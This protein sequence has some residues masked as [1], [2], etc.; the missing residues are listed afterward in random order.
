MTRTAAVVVLLALSPI[1][2][3]Q[4][5]TR[6]AIV[7]GAR[8][9]GDPTWHFG[10]W[11]IPTASPDPVTVEVGTFTFRAQGVGFATAWYKTYIDPTGSTSACSA[12]IIEDTINGIPTSGVDGRVGVYNGGAQTQSVFTNRGAGVPG[13][14]LRISSSSDT[15]DASAAGGIR[16]HQSG[17]GNPPGFHE[18][19]GELG[20]LFA[21]TAQP[22]ILEV[23]TYT[24]NTP[25]S[26]I[27]S[28]TVYNELNSNTTT[29]L[30]TVVSVDA[31]TLH[32]AWIPA[33]STLTLLSLASLAVARRRR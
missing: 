3:A 11:Y 13:T 27:N 12:A 1:A 25:L 28:Y 16:V 10:D 2:S 8:L 19:D 31:L 18:G 26:R 30:K 4:P 20:F 22:G 21:L 14:G 17:P 23:N 15:A 9:P 7:Y 32:V 5:G 24:I 29:E 6:N 33:P